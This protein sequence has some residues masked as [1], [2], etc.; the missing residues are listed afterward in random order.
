MIS[1]GIEEGLPILKLFLD[2]SVCAPQREFLG[3]LTSPN[4]SFSIL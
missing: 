2:L 1:I 3:T 4:V